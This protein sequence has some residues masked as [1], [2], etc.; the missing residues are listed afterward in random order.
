MIMK[1]SSVFE[2]GLSLP[3]FMWCEWAMEILQL[4]LDQL[5]LL[6]GLRTIH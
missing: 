4:V 6:P 5:L 1:K 3:H 2:K